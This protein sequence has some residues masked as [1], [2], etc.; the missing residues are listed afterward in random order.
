MRVNQISSAV[1]GSVGPVHSSGGGS[2][3]QTSQLLLHWLD[4]AALRQR[5]LSNNLANVNTPGYTRQDVTFE[6]ALNEALK[7]GPQALDHFQP[8]VVT[9]HASPARLDGNNVQLETEL[10]EMSKNALAYQTAMQ[11]LSMKMSMERM[12]VTGRSA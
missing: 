10:S 6:T 7:Q 12:A 1:A 8:E 11:L 3:D 5:V 4:G 9:D 2:D